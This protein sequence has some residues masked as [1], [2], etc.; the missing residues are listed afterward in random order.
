MIARVWTWFF[1]GPQKRVIKV[2]NKW[3]QSFWVN[4]RSVASLQRLFW[5]A[6]TN[7]HKPVL[8]ENRFELFW[9]L[10]ETS[11]ECVPSCKWLRWPPSAASC[12]WQSSTESADVRWGS[13]RGTCRTSGT[14]A[15]NPTTAEHWSVWW[16]QSTSWQPKENHVK[17]TIYHQ[18][19]H[20]QAKC[21]IESL[22]VQ[23]GCIYLT[24]WNIVT[25]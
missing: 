19:L 22:S 14:P 5:S 13:V 8:S 12:L 15:S 18:L 7:Q 20:Y 4:F 17:N 11:V 21:S 10:R 9:V 3:Q 2:C 24:M 25:I 6:T 16:S 23:Q 1:N